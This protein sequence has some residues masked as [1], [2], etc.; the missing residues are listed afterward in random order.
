MSNVG[1]AFIIDGKVVKSQNQWYNK[2]VAKIKSDKPGDYWDD[3]LATITEKRN[4][5]MRDNVNKAARFV[6]NWCIEH[7]IGTIV[8]GWNQGQKDSINIGKINNQQFVQIPTAKL[9]ARIAELSK[10]YGIEFVETEESYTSK[11]S[12]LDD[13]FL[14]TFGEKPERWEA[15]GKRVNRGLYRSAVGKL[16]NA[17]A[18]GAGN[19]IRKVAIQLSLD[20]AKVSR[21]VLMLPQRYQLNNLTKKYRK[22]C[23]AWQ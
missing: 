20:L 19:I 22:Q 4:R 9:K 23:V 5:M 3:N 13:D 6:I 15:S 12:F 17:D 11:A 21:E 16:I 10:Q 7:Q 1:K 2:Q 14:P 8:F 18:N